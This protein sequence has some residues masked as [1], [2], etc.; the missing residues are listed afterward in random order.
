MSRQCMQ[1][2]GNSSEHDGMVTLPA[3]TAGHLR[4]R[5]QKEGGGHLAFLT[6]ALSFMS[7]LQ[8]LLTERQRSL[9]TVS[10]LTDCAPSVSSLTGITMLVCHP[11]VGTA[12]AFGVPWS[13]RT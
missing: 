8:S 1:H 2:T 9:T 10:A 6:F 13:G 3:T 11:R 5:G 4:L 7:A 12:G